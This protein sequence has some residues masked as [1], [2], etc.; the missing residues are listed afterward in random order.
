MAHSCKLWRVLVRA[1]GSAH[2][3]SFGWSRVSL[4][5]DRSCLCTRTGFLQA[6]PCL[7]ASNSCQVRLKRKHS[8]WD[9]ICALVLV[10]LGARAADHSTLRNV[11][12][13]LSGHYRRPQTWKK[14]SHTQFHLEDR[15]AGCFKSGLGSDGVFGSSFLPFWWV[16]LR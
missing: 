16:R 8:F 11:D 4:R 12:K 6:P 5:D 3:S 9:H 1:H 14:R 7:S 2:R 10:F 13:S 15:G